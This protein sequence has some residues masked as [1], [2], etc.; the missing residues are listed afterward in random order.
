MAANTAEPD[1]P[2]SSSANLRLVHPTPQEKEATWR[3][4][5]SAWRGALPLDTYLRRE[6]YL[7]S[8]PL[9]KDGGITYWILVD[10]SKN[11][12]APEPKSSDD[13]SQSPR[14]ILSSC[15]SLRK[16]ALFARR[17]FGLGK[18]EVQEIVAH[19]IGSVFCNPA[20]RGLGYAG[21][22]M[23]EL[24]KN[25]ERWQ[26]EA[27]RKAHFTVLYSDIGKQFYAKRGWRARESRHIALPAVVNEGNGESK[28]H[29]LEVK[30]LHA[31]NLSTLC[32]TDEMWIRESIVRFEKDGPDTRVALIPDV[33]TMQWH[34][35]REEFTAKKVL[36]RW[37][38]VKGVLIDGGPGK[39]V[40][41]IWTRTFAAKESENVLHILRLVVQ[42]E[43]EFGAENHMNESDLNGNTPHT[44]AVRAVEAVLRAARR[45]AGRWGMRTVEIWNP[46][47]I[48]VKAAQSILHE[49]TVVERDEESIA[50]LMWYGPGE[51]EWV[52]NEKYG[53]C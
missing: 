33:N 47:P 11:A 46:A 15:E 6:H 20:Y 43:S 7:A 3:L 9:T 18:A 44:V 8:Q 50:S 29:E 49:T 39:L 28:H 14:T 19:G 35:A 21:R 45:E 22:M 16:R 12:D 37:P 24:G 48:V 51:V 25:L 53:W 2:R 42:G 26:Q 36:G 27:E 31:D 32:D 52:E 1:L 17:P 41:A 13:V 30:E 38:D 4:N 40:W 5:G 23:E 10:D 34:H